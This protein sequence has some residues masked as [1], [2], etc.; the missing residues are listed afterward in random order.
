MKFIKLLYS[1]IFTLALFYANG[2]SE[3]SKSGRIK[4]TISTYLPISEKAVDLGILGTSFSYDWRYKPAWSIRGDIGA[5]GRILARGEIY[6]INNTDD[7]YMVVRPSLGLATRFYYNHK[8]M[9]RTELPKK[10][11]KFLGLKMHYMPDWFTLWIK[12]IE[13]LRWSENH[14][15]LEFIPYWGLRTQKNRVFF[16]MNVGYMIPI[17]HI[18]KTEWNDGS[19]IHFACRVG[20]RF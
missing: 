8:K 19:R 18:F 16:E 5:R 11:S 20:Y 12:Q 15:S 14:Q 13:Q 10:T 9:I 17:K 1:L 7:Y 6:H 4:G 3:A 2:Q